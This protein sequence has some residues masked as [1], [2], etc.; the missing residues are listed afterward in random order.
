MAGDN[1]D[2]DQDI[3]GSHFGNDDEEEDEEEL[4]AISDRFEQHR[5]KRS[6]AFTSPKKPENPGREKYYPSS[7]VSKLGL[8]AGSPR[9][10]KNPGEASHGAA[11]HFRAAHS[12]DERQTQATQRIEELILQ[13]GQEG[14]LIVRLHPLR[15][16]QD[17]NVSF[18]VARYASP[19]AAGQA[20]PFMPH[21]HPQV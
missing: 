10:G 16:D 21:A 11:V 12:P 14:K 13:P 4:R 20:K 1:A 8:A 19:P 15:T 2:Q 18:F 3:V 7:D 6:A 9:H 5:K 17:D